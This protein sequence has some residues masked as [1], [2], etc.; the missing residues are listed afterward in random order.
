MAR[1]RIDPGVHTPP[2]PRLRLGLAI[3]LG[4]TLFGSL[5]AMA[6]EGP[7]WAALAVTVGVAVSITP[8]LLRVLPPLAKDAKT[9]KRDPDHAVTVVALLSYVAVVAGFLVLLDLG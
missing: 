8:I 5:W 1:A 9:N 7:K 4:A 6:D 3:A 2:D